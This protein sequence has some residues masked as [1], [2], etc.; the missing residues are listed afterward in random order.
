MSCLD[1][2]TNINETFIIEPT[3]VNRE[4]I[5]ACTAV[6]TNSI[7]GCS[8][9]TKIFMGTGVITFDGNL[10][11]NNAITAD[12]IYASTYYSGGTNLLDIFSS[13]DIYLTGGTFDNNVDTLTLYNSNG[14]TIIV[15]GFTDYYTTGTTLVGKTVYFN[16]TDA[17]S[18]YT[19]DL[20]SFSTEDIY[21]TGLT[22]SNNQ[23]IITR[24]D[25][26][27]LNTYINYFTGL[28]IG[29]LIADS[30]SATTISATTFYGDGS[31]LTGI[32]TYRLTGSSQNGNSL[33][34]FNSTG[35]TEIFTPES[36]TGGT[37]TKSSGILSLT[38][39]TGG[40]I[41]ITG[42]TDVFVTGGTYNPTNGIATFTNT[43]GGTF[44]VSGFNAGVPNTYIQDV[45]T[46]L[47]QITLEDNLGT[48]YT[49][50][51]SIIT[52]GT[53]NQT[54]GILSLI[55]SS[56]NSINISGFLTGVTDTFVTGGTYSNGTATFV[57][58]TGGT[59]SVGGFLTGQTFTD[60]TITGGT[61]NQN[62][63]VLSL[64]NNTGGTVT[65]TGI[66]DSF[67]TGGTYSAGTLSIVNNTG[68]TVTI[69][70]F[71]NGIIAGSGTTNYV[72]KWSGST[73]LTDSQIIDDGTNVGIGLNPSYKLDVGGSVQLGQNTT[74]STRFFGGQSVFSY[75][76]QGLSEYRLYA[77]NMLFLGG[78]GTTRVAFGTAG[79]NNTTGTTEAMLY[80]GDVSNTSGTKSGFGVSFR[81]LHSSGSGVVN[82]FNINPN[83]DQASANT[84]TIRG[85]YYNPTFS[86][87]LKGTNIA[88]ENTT[89]NN[90]LNSAG[91]NTGIGITGSPTNKL[92]ISAATDPL[93]V[94]GLINEVNNTLLNVDVSGIVHTMAVSA[95][96][97]QFIT[98]GTYSN[99][100]LSLVNSTGGTVS[101]AGF[102]TGTTSGST[103]GTSIL[104]TGGTY[105]N[106]TLTLTNST[107]G[108]VTVTGFT[109]GTTSG[110]NVLI[111]GGTFTNNSLTLTNSTGGT[112]ST[113]IET[114]T[115]ITATTNVTVNALSGTSSALAGINSSGTFIALSAATGN[116]IANTISGN[117]L[118]SVLTRDFASGLISGAV[119]TIN[120]A[121][122]ATFNITS[123]VGYI[124]DWWTTPGQPTLYPVSISAQTGVTLTYLSSSTL[125]YIGIDKTGTLVQYSTEPTNSQ[126]RQII[127]LGQLGHTNLTSIGNV[128][129]FTTTYEGAN[130]KVLDVISEL[131]LINT[132]NGLS[133][134]G[135]NLKFNKAN[136]YLFGLGV[137][138]RNDFSNPN[139][140]N[141]PSATPVSFKYRTQTGGT[142][143]T[144]TDIDPTK[145]DVGGVITTIPGSSNAATNQRIYLFPNGNVIV[146]YGQTIYTSLS[147]A[148]AAHTT[149]TFTQ[150]SNVSAAAILIGILSVT[151][152]C[153][154]LSNSTNA[155]FLPVSKFGE[156]LAGSIGVSTLTL[157]QTYDNSNTPEIITDSAR[158]AL[159]I[160]RGS[161]ADT[162]N[163]FEGQNGSNVTTSSID[164][165]GFGKFISLSATSITANSY[166]ITGITSGHEIS[167][168]RYANDTNSAGF[169]SY[170]SR[171]T[172]TTPSAIQSG[173]TI[174]VFGGRG[175]FGTGFTSTSKAN[176]S[177]IASENWSSTNQ[178]TYLSFNSTT[179]GSTNRTEVMKIDNTGLWV[180]GNKFINGTTIS[181]TTYQNLPTDIFT[182]G[183]TY[184]KSSGIL[185]LT[186]NT[187]GTFTV[188]GITD[189]VTTGG[190][191]NQSTRTL[192]LTNNTGGTFTVTGI[193]DVV[194]TGGTYST[195]QVVLNN[196]TGGTTTI[197]RS[198][199]TDWTN[200]SAI[201]GITGL[202]SL[203]TKQI[204]YMVMGK[205]MFVQFDFRCA[206]PNSS[207][208][209]TSFTLPFNAS[210]W[211]GE[212]RGIIHGVNSTTQATM[213]WRIVA[214]TN[215]VEVANGANDTNFSAWTNATARRI[216]GQMI[217]NI[218]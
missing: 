78:A 2:Q 156:S 175:Y 169:I 116:T 94:Q 104:I 215:V 53:Y 11:T 174:G 125:S 192:S 126:R 157:Q 183:G 66:T 5:S 122:T 208:T 206:S 194:T 108:T 22:F 200:Y 19:L 115:G 128:N 44:N 171:G 16:R 133:P 123:G 132:G 114:F 141:T 50:N 118:I 61:F 45:F 72:P 179:S 35:G 205:T 47:Y 186:N 75:N 69:S 217:I 82:I 40:T 92:H 187:G 12:T 98:G 135:A 201:V 73:G 188:T 62:T 97:G 216:E 182:T 10:Y 170:K 121:N 91:D 189:V 165:N 144:I 85:F 46:T 55:N 96:T 71:Q 26:V 158:G 214:G 213:L 76:P 31:Q 81:S 173:D 39:N 21:T 95:V 202:T 27:N 99:G 7:I 83:F 90:L 41:T 150:Y 112:V 65:V 42:I 6:Y 88:F 164:G 110:S 204:Q 30:I 117:S 212:Q 180:N 176:I 67:I 143:T 195:S 107:G 33:L 103:S 138:A 162:D 119:I 139:K 140:V 191:F 178:G 147:N 167:L 148:I 218:A 74:H 48:T 80:L 198:D 58:N 172:S 101:I 54:T 100:T 210:S 36:I 15:T 60:T 105:S 59:F 145:Y 199:F 155:I 1:N 193:T 181:A 13:R 161:T 93:R 130:A 64:V 149:E 63:R 68:G 56:G 89:G 9:D 151:K 152:G 106:G 28:T 146:Q 34:L 137:N 159:T 102:T 185:T 160:Q 211:A 57:N 37:Y 24:N 190:T 136:G 52:G 142:G 129:S 197:T 209:T 196:N 120:S 3:V 51:P 168:Y 23:I 84:S 184:T 43:T 163:I 111:T 4:V 49:F 79:G 127:L 29:N 8:G 203:T 17:L 124:V 25:G 134:N 113:R 32:N 166:T 14:S 207:G 20:S 70:G 153:T 77:N 87:T 131:H 86:Q 109:T 154:D 38:N 18:A 177:L